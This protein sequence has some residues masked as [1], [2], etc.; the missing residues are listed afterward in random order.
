MSSAEVTWTVDS[1]GQWV[2]DRSHHTGGATPVVQHI[3]AESMRTGMTRVME[4]LGAPLETI[5]VRFVNGFFYTR[6]RPLI[7]ADK[8]AK[9]LPPAFVLKIATRLHPAFRRRSKTAARVFETEPWKKVIH[10]WH[11][12]G[13]DEVERKNLALQDVD[14]AAL[15]DAGAVEHAR[16]CLDHCVE[17]WELHFWLHGYDLGPLGRFLADSN[18]RWGLPAARL[19]PLLE[20]ASPSTSAPKRL[21]RRIRDI[22]EASGREPSTLAELRAISPEVAAA[23]DDY[24]RRRGAVLFSRY[25]VDGVTLGERPDLVF[26]SIMNAETAD[27]VVDIEARAAAVR[28]DI[29]AAEQRDFDEML[30]Q[31]R[32]AMDLRDDNGPMTAE[33]PLG[34][35]RHALLEVGRRLHA[36]GRAH[37]VEHALELRPEELTAELFSG[38]AP[39]ADELALRAADRRRQAALD[40]PP[41]I[42]PAEAA[43]PLDVLPA[44]LARIVNTIQTLM[45]EMGMDAGERTSGLEGAGIGTASVTGRACVATS[46]EE[47]L[48]RLEPGDILV[49]ACTTPAYNLVLSIAGGVV[50]SEGGPM[51]HA[52]VLARELGIPAVIGAKAAITDIPHGAEIEI[53]PVAGRVRVLATS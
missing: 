38:E 20:G 22:V 21:L 35:L 25:D 33:W 26:A 13:R 40:P 7:G 6:L 17:S 15:D 1:P 8:P 10:D 53:D 18:S 12:G 46:P 2:L 16:R 37:A 36:T 30:R 29:P 52:A 50:T 27:D 28:A 45:R 14:L 11:H 4:E 31:A 3:Q 39:S 41:T 9:K 24:L 47:A 42:G 48:D 5:D 34:L 51:S 43:P 19:L 44:P 49:V 32:E 23:V